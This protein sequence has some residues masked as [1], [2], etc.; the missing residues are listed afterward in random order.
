MST[1]SDPITTIRV[2]TSARDRLAE[3]AAETHLPITKVAG[4]A[5][6]QFDPSQLQ[7][8]FGGTRDDASRD[9]AS[10]ART[11]EIP[12]TNI[13]KARTDARSRGEKEPD[14]EKVGIV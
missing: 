12:G 7:H 13:R 9:D 5:I 11:R 14:L 6:R 3:I 1:K 8:L 2:A 4:V 10:K